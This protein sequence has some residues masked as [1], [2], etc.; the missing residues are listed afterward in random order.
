MTEPCQP[1]M[2]PHANPS[3]QPIWVLMLTHARTYEEA[4]NPLRKPSTL[5]TRDTKNTT[6]NTTQTP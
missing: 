3:C 4:Y 5:L 1:H 6:N 2:P